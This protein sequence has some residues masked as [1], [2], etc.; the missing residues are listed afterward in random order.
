MSNRVAS[1]D[2][3]TSTPD[4]L[5]LSSQR[6]SQRA[7]IASA[8]SSQ[9]SISHHSSYRSKHPPD[10]L[11]LHMA[12]H[13]MYAQQHSSNKRPA[14]PQRSDTLKPSK[15]ATA[16]STMAIPS[17]AASQVT[18]SDTFLQSSLDDTGPG[19]DERLPRLSMSSTRSGSTNELKTP[20]SLHQSWPYD[21][22]ADSPPASLQTS[23]AAA[24]VSHADDHQR[25]P[26]HNDAQHVST[27]S[28]DPAMHIPLRSP[29]LDAALVQLDTLALQHPTQLERLSSA[30]INATSKRSTLSDE[31]WPNTATQSR[32]ESQRSHLLS[33]RDASPLVA[34]ATESNQAHRSPSLDADLPNRAS[35]TSPDSWRSLLPEHDPYFASEGQLRATQLGPSASPQN[36]HASPSAFD[37]DTYAAAK[38]SSPVINHDGM[39]CSSFDTTRTSFSSN[40]SG[41]SARSTSGLYRSSTQSQHSARSDSWRSLLPHDDRFHASG[42]ANAAFMSQGLSASPNLASRSLSD[43]LDSPSL[44]DGHNHRAAF[45]ALDAPRSSYTVSVGDVDSAARRHAS[46]SSVE[47]NHS[48]QFAATRI[49]LTSMRHTAGSNLECT[50][51]S[52]ETESS[53]ACALSDASS[54]SWRLSRTADDS[55]EG[56]DMTPELSQ[57]TAAADV[58]DANER[59][60]WPTSRSGRSVRHGSSSPTSSGPLTPETGQTPRAKSLMTAVLDE[61]RAEARDATSALL[62][63]ETSDSVVKATQDGVMATTT[64]TNPTTT[65]TTATR[66]QLLCDTTATARA[67]SKA[68]SEAGGDN[69]GAMSAWLEQDTEDDMLQSQPNKGRTSSCSISTPISPPSLPFLERRPAPPETDLVI[70]TERTRYTLVTRLPGFSLDCITLATKQHAHHRTLHIV[71]DKWD[72]EGGGHFERRITFPDK[73]CDL[74]NVKAE[75]DGNTLR[76]Y[77]P[78]KLATN[79]FSS[80]S[81]ATF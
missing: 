66:T 71:A 72:T 76:V 20:E 56:A 32:T 33:H 8:G 14:A 79:R 9:S 46:F 25:K 35:M 65:T 31:S 63:S 3:H 62:V 7:S 74:I 47:P 44:F 69:G 17:S 59:D 4:S 68:R 45:F 73:E 51:S 78:R 55:L 36:I 13:S 54:L 49:M 6:A 50:K 30:A 16:F 38:A 77:V 10:T 5:P 53:Q 26:S 43:H 67:V 48:K 18:R 27:H 2:S 60:H 81:S 12:P 64:T 39:S 42:D 11:A 57:S 28:T 70:E 58:D 22:Q 52:S 75:F 34:A 40:V 61:A 15:Q 21:V 37:I 1:Q 23:S 41:F 80:A 24:R 29:E 19:S